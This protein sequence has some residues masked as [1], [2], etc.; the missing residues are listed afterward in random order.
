MHM[1]YSNYMYYLFVYFDHQ[2]WFI[3]IIDDRRR[4]IVHFFIPVEKQKQKQT[5]SFSF[6]LFASCFGCMETVVPELGLL[7]LSG[8]GI[9]RND[10]RDFS[11]RLLCLYLHLSNIYSKECDM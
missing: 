8:V 4:K 7:L 10:A 9:I 1:S 6:F 11:L 2:Y 3:S 5:D